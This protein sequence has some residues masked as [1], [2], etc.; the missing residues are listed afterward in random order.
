MLSPGDR[1][2]CS[3]TSSISSRVRRRRSRR[4][5]MPA[6]RRS[7]SRAESGSS[8]RAS[9]CIRSPRSSRRRQ[10]S[11]SP[12]GLPRSGTTPVTP[13]RSRSSARRLDNLPLAVELAAAR[14]GL[15]R[16]GRDSLAAWRPPRPAQGRPRRRPAPAD[17][18]RHD[19]SG[20]T[21]CSTGRERELFAR[22]A[23][24]AGGG[25]LEAVEAV[26]E[27]DLDVLSS[28]LDKSLVRRTGERRVDARD[29][30]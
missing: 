10:P 26:C 24:F 2:C 22:L 11:C 5:G 6:G 15:S 19:R 7:S 16:T 14:T 18:P 23:V 29:D 27:A 9:T 1:S 30:P 20:L 25:T 13:T 28:L 21:T 12:R 3:T 8:S 4:F 17:A